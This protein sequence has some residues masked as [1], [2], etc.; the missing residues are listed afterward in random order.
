MVTLLL[1]KGA[2][3]NKDRW[4]NTPLYIASLKGHVEIV[5]LLLKAPGI[6]VNKAVKGVIDTPLVIACKNGKHAVVE[7][8][9]EKQGIDVKIAD[10]NGRKP[11]Y[12]ASGGK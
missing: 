10:S 11:L 4:G 7:A 1:A 5:R 6:Q 12:I 2:D 3:V 8:L 9:L